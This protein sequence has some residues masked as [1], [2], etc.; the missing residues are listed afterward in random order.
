MIGAMAVSVAA[1]KNVPLF[2]E[3]DD[4]EVAR[5]ANEFKERT[6]PAGASVVSEG[7]SGAAFFVITDGQ[8]TVTV[9]GEERARLGRGDHF[10]EIALLDEGVRSATV[11]ADTEL[12]CY[13]LTPWEFRP[14]V[15]EHPQI[16]WK[17][18]QALARRLRTIETT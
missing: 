6:F 16:A 8:A 18:L 3:L 7:A 1:L 11:T 17:L 2:A 12:R 4:R 9:R 5:L 14:F 10:G 15:E 13:G